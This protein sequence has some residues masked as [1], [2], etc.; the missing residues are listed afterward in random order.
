MVRERL[1]EVRL[2]TLKIGTLLVGGH[3]G[4]DDFSR[5]LLGRFNLRVS[6]ELSQVGNVIEALSFAAKPHPPENASV[7]PPS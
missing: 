1:V 4:V 7:R 5:G 3:T 2:L 6:D